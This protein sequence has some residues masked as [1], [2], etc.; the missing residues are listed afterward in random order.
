M[1]YTFCQKGCDILEENNKSNSHLEELREYSKIVN[2]ALKDSGDRDQK[3]KI[4]L[5]IALIATNL[6]WGAIQF[7]TTYEAYK[8]DTSKVS[9]EQ[10]IGKQKQTYEKSD[11]DAAIETKGDS[12]ISE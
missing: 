3:I 4:W 11:G 9:V 12:N 1:W 10:D 6:F 8:P 2:S 5:I 7:Y